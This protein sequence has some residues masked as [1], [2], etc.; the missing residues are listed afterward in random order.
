MED[1]GMGAGNG[2]RDAGDRRPHVR[3]LLALLGAL[4]VV[5]VLPPAAGAL[6][7]AFLD[8][9][10]PQLLT[11]PTVTGDPRVG[12]TLTCDRGSWDDSAA[13]PY[14]Y[15]I[16]WMRGDFEYIEDA[17]AA[18]YVVTAQD[19]GL[20]L[21]CSVRVV[22]GQADRY[23]SSNGLFAREP[24]SRSAPRISGDPRI[25]GE[26]R[27]SRGVWDDRGLTP[28][29][30]AFGWTRDGEPIEDA[31]SDRYTVTAADLDN[32]LACSVTAAEVTTASSAETFP[33]PPAEPR[34]AG[35]RRRSAHRRRR[36]LHSRHLGRRGPHALRG[37][38]PLAERRRAD[39]ARGRLGLHRRPR[40]RRR[41][42]DVRGRRRGPDRRSRAC[43]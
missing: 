2:F 29:A 27:C 10:W 40:R 17:T 11:P 16:H 7:A 35:P 8:Y 12:G 20:P 21:V 30:T 3:A 31:T 38:L 42:A 43:R 9:H 4:L 25:G 41:R 36:D 19:A 28:Y 6:R 23:E 14:D 22:N 26:L 1:S 15:E 13:A 37:R 5:A 33:E 24:E 18:D 34:P 32:P 39:P